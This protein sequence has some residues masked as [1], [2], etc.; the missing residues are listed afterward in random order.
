M[1]EGKLLGQPP[2]PLPSPAVPLLCAQPRVL[3]LC[4]S[5]ESVIQPGLRGGGRDQNR[6]FPSP[7]EAALGEVPKMLL[8]G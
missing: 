5:Q 7:T 3:S 1:E 8:G 4:L 2:G 6:A